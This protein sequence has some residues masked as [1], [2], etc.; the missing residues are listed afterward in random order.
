[1]QVAAPL[2]VLGMVI[3]SKS[4]EYLPLPLCANNLINNTVWG[5]YAIMKAD[6]FVGVG[7]S[8]G[9]CFILYIFLGY[10]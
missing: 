4:A 2:S 10:V 5:V 1:M 7:L 3:R 8:S 6:I 9:A